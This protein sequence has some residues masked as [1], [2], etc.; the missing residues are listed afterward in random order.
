MAPVALLF[1]KSSKQVDIILIIEVKFEWVPRVLRKVLSAEQKL[2]GRYMFV[3]ERERE[4]AMFPIF[5]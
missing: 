4:R 2:R 3:I 5:M 1:M